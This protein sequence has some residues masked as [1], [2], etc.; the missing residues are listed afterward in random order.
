MRGNKWR[1]EVVGSMWGRGDDGRYIY[2]SMGSDGVLLSIQ[3][4]G[5]AERLNLFFF[6]GRGKKLY[7]SDTWCLWD[8]SKSP[9][10]ISSHSCHDY[11]FDSHIGSILLVSVSMQEHLNLYL[12]L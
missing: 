8:E 4:E 10:N 1:E 7:T 3:G 9:G 11:V 2:T 6:G 12:Y 5:V